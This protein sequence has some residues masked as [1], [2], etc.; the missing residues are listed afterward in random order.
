[1]NRSIS[2]W[3]EHRTDQAIFVQRTLNKWFSEKSY[4]VIYDKLIFGNPDL[5][6]EEKD[7]QVKYTK[8]YFIIA[9]SHTMAMYHDQITIVCIEPHSTE[10]KEISIWRSRWHEISIQEDVESWTIL[11]RFYP[12]E[13]KEF[14]PLLA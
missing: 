11:R 3:D 5:F 6:F 9:V 12:F 10:M 13:K 1:M 7:Y 14:K 8:Y 4:Q 2:V